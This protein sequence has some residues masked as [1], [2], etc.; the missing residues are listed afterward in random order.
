[1]RAASADDIPIIAELT[2]GAYVDGG[3][4]PADSPYADTLRDVEPRLKET[5][6]LTD[7]ESGHV[8]AAVAVLPSGHA[9]AEVAHTG[10]W[11]FRYLAVRPDYWGRGLAQRLIDAA[12]SRAREAGATRM[13][14]RVIDT[15]H[16]AKRL[17][18]HLGYEH[19]PERDFTFESSSQPGR[20]MTLFLMQKPLGSA[21][22]FG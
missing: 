4:L 3:H 9:M 14:L 13:V 19:V 5:I 21:P 11:E 10:E 22:E 1:M 2:V 12:E 16:R 17:Y 6:V 7:G 18:E 15:N 20:M 8:I